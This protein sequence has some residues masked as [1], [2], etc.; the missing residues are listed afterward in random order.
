MKFGQFIEYDKRDKFL[1]KNRA[2][3]EE[4]MLVSDLFLFV[5]IDLHQ[6]KASGLQLSFNIYRQPLT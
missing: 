6:V 4:G 1:F 5:K 3:N 2:Q